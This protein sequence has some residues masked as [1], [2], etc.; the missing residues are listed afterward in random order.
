MAEVPRVGRGSVEAI[1][2]GS[3]GIEIQI[4]EVPLARVTLRV[5]SGFELANLVYL[6]G[7]IKPRDGRVVELLELKPLEEF[8]DPAG[9]P[10]RLSEKII[11]VAGSSI[12][13]G[14]LRVN[15]GRMDGAEVT[16]EVEPGPCVFGVRGATI[17][18]VS[19]FPVGT[20]P[21]L[22]EPGKEYT[23]ILHLEPSA[24]LALTVQEHP[25]RAELFA[26][27]LLRDGTPVTLEVGRGRMEQLAALGS[28]GTL[29]LGPVPARNLTLALGTLAE[30]AAGRS[31]VSFL[32]S[33]RPGQEL[34]VNVELPD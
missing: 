13:E 19:C 8:K 26:S 7:S 2:S 27:L 31:T 14:E 33:P 24:S 22:T 10:L 6:R 34:P 9:W 18:G 25:L 17:D 3:S 16:L 21:V 5:V 15:T 28:D 29:R 23:V 12:E 11:G 20:G 30:L 32:V 1:P 4:E